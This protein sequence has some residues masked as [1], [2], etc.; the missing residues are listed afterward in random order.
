MARLAWLLFTLTCILSALSFVFL[1]L[2]WATPVPDIFG[3]RGHVVIVALTFGSIGLLLARRH[4]ENPI[5]WLLLA[6]GLVNAIVESCIEYAT[7]AL[8]TKLGALPYG[9]LAAWIASWLWIIAIDLLIYAFLLFPSGHL[10]SARWRPVAWFVVGAFALMT[11]A[12]MIRP[13]PLHFAAYRDNPFAVQVAYPVLSL[14]PV[15]NAGALLLIGIS[16]IMR[17]RRAVGIER[18]QLKWFAYAV[19]LRTIIGLTYSVADAAGLEGLVPRFYQYLTVATWIAIPFVIAIAI[20]RYRLWDID[21]IINRTLVYGALTAGVVGLYVLTVGWL[22]MMLQTQDYLLTNVFAIVMIAFL[23]QPLRQLLQGIADLFVPVPRSAPRLE[24]HEHQMTIPKGQGASDTTM[25]GRWLLIARLVWAI[26]FIALTAMYTFGFMEVREALSTVCEEERCTLRQQT[27]HTE[28]G[29][30]VMNWLGSP[31]G[32]ADRLRP[33]Q[34]EALERLGWTLD[35]YGWL[36]ALQMGIPILIYVLIAA[37]LYW[38]KSDDWM[39]LFV[40]TMIMTFPLADMPLPFTLAVR[41]PVWQW[42]LAPANFVATSS[43]LIFPLVFPNG[44]FVPR[45]TRW[46]I[47]FDFV[48]A[49]I[50]TLWQ[51]SILREPP[52]SDNLV[53]AYVFLSFSISVYAQPY[54]YFRVASLVERQQIKWVV[55]GLVVFLSIAFPLLWPLDRLLRAQAGSMDLVQALVLSAIIDSLFRAIALLDRKSVV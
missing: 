6:A 46:K 20:L 2:S 43:F 13:G 53:F 18:Q 25:R 11:F 1:A 37:G 28:A 44:Q 27:R 51:N 47:F 16:V 48:F 15:A 14:I 33:D 32:Y 30:Q 10:P 39:V 49:V 50:L 21:I 26:G 23:F 22:S 40:S 31:M 8:L 38:R 35:Q 4:P 54:R 5:G 34:V 41:Q 19:T 7:Y 52:S 24:Q 17:F 29:E 12:F 45:W 3:F 55:V 42:V 36:A 9:T